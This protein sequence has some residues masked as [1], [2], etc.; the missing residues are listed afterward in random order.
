MPFR[1]SQLQDENLPLYDEETGRGPYEGI[2]EP[3]EDTTQ[4]EIIIVNKYGRL[5]NVLEKELQ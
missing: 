1:Q 4:F 5:F 3:K 2:I